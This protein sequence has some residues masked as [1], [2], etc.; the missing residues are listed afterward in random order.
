MS[1]KNSFGALS[2]DDTDD[3]IWDTNEHGKEANTILN[4]SDSDVEEHIMEDSNGKCIAE[5]EMK[6]AS[7]PVTEVSND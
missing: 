5:I 1:V 4:E 2:M 3:N 7:T 6:G